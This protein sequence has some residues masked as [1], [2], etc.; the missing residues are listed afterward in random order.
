MWFTSIKVKTETKRDDSVELSRYTKNII[1]NCLKHPVFLFFKVPY[2]NDKILKLLK[3]SKENERIQ[4]SQGLICD[5]LS[6]LLMKAWVEQIYLKQPDQTK[7]EKL[8]QS[9][10]GDKPDLLWAEYYQT[11]S[12]PME[13]LK[14]FPMGQYIR[15]IEYMLDRGKD[16]SVFQIGCSSGREIAYFAKKYPDISFYG[17]D[18]SAGA[19]K[20]SSKNHQMDNLHFEVCSA[21]D[22]TKMIEKYPSKNILL[23]SSVALQYVQ[24][25]HLDQ[26]FESIRNYKNLTV[27]FS[28]SG[29][30][31]NGSPDAIKGS[32]YWY[33]FLQTHNYKYYAEKNGF[34][35][36]KCLFMQDGEA[37]EDLY[38]KYD[39]NY[40]PI[41][42]DLNS[43]MYLYF[44]RSS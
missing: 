29:S 39:N 30:T 43:V 12:P 34:K 26:M 19:I 21:K 25:E 2:L 17:T 24:P 40:D 4:L 8:K 16:F 14:N 9:L 35:T 22:I 5:L 11:T 44:G 27:V 23:F 10:L 13:E 7:R 6:R 18:I 38:E 1:Y 15:E 3:R 28:E 32:L 31:E 33:E 41:K 37:E 20:F 36:I 42:D